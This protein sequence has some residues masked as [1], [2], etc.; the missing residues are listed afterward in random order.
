MPAEDA[1]L[2]LAKTLIAERLAACVSIFPEMRSVYR[3]EGRIEQGSEH[4]I[5]MK[6][7][8]G[9]VAA[10]HA[11]LEALHPYAVAEILDIPASGGGDAYLAWVAK[12][13]D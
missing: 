7:T 11:R 13:V 8:P 1:A 12:S 10:L 9:K 2:D 3:W 6:T 5:V 4:Q